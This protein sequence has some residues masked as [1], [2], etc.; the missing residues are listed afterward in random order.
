MAAWINKNIMIV[1]IAM[2][3]IVFG[4]DVYLIFRFLNSPNAMGIIFGGTFLSLL[5]VIDRLRRI[6][7]EKSI[8]E[9]IL[10]LLDG[11]PK[12]QIATVIETLYW[13][14]I[15]KSKQ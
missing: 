5:T 15:R 12:E 1:Y 6:W 14:G 10:V 9:M 4:I 11:L 8:M 13:N 2:L 7:K 3:C